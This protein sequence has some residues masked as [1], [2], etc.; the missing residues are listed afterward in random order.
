MYTVTCQAA[1]IFF[2]LSYEK[3]GMAIGGSH[4]F[5]YYTRKQWC[6][7]SH[8]SYEWMHIREKCTV[9]WLAATDHAVPIQTCVLCIAGFLVVQVQTILIPAHTVQRC[10]YRIQNFHAHRVDRVISFFSSR[11]NW[12]SPTP[13]HAGE[14]VPPPLVQGEGTHSLAGERVGESQFLRGDRHC[15]MLGI[16][17]LCGHAPK[18]SPGK[19]RLYELNVYLKYF[20]N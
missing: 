14:C 4:F 1:T 19:L 16:Y 12:D 15:G 10:T 18:L 6:F 20:P 5:A 17:V 9:R 13:S 8:A 7:I 3:T 2:T 11:R